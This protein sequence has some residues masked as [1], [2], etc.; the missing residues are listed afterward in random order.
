MKEVR[1]GCSGWSYD[2]WRERFYPA[3]TPA[4]RRLSHYASVFD[5]VEVN[6][7]FYRLP[8][9][10]SVRS[11]VEQVPDGFLFAVKA[12]RYL[13][14]GRRVIRTAAWQSG[15]PP[16]EPSPVRWSPVVTG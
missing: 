16:V 15:I 5:T 14:T 3:R 13:T 8:K 4:S 10:D 12:S 1:I 6:A 9:V 11:W 2:E 7:T